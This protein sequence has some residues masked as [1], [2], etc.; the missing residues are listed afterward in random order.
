LCGSPRS[1]SARA[2]EQSAALQWSAAAFR[3]LL[4]RDSSF[5]QRI[6]R[7]SLRT[8]L[9]KERLLIDSLTRSPGGDRQID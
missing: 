8:L 1:A 7:E 3:Q 9:E 4:L 6:F 2:S 5:S